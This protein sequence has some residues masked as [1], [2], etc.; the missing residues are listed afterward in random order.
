MDAIA[1]FA[2][3]KMSV[4]AKPSQ[5]ILFVDL[6]EVEEPSKVLQQLQDQGYEPQL[7]LID[8]KIGL[9]VIAVLRDES[10][11]TDERHTEISDEWERLALQVF[12]DDPNKA[13]R[14]WCGIKAEAAKVKEGGE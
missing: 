12:P 1:Q 13:V 8:L 7:R 4:G 3:L 6:S 14:L 2:S 10:N 11:V 5:A 9:H